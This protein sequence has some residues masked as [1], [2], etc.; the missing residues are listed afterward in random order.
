MDDWG[1][2]DWGGRK[3][4][5][6]G[7]FGD[8]GVRVLDPKDFKARPKGEGEGRRGKGMGLGLTRSNRA[9]RLPRAQRKDLALP[10]EGRTRPASL[11][12][13]DGLCF[14]TGPGTLQPTAPLA[15]TQM[16]EKEPAAHPRE[17]EAWLS[18]AALG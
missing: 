12:Y 17:F 15:R 4:S 13:P 2:G 1:V 14:S 7:I 10:A 11:P 6:R 5:W 9:S 8:S 18:K 16:P 3:D